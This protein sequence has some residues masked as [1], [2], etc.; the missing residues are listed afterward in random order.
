MIRCCFVSPW[1]SSPEKK[2]KI[3][4]NLVSGNEFDWMKSSLRLLR[5]WAQCFLLP[6]KSLLL[7]EELSWSWC[8]VLTSYSAAPGP[9]PRIWQVSRRGLSFVAFL[10]VSHELWSCTCCSAR[11]VKPW[12]QVATAL[13]HLLAFLKEDCE[14]RDHRQ[15]G[16]DRCEAPWR[17]AKKMTL[18]T[19]Y[20]MWTGRICGCVVAQV[21]INAAP[22]P[23]R[24]GVHPRA[25][26][27]RPNAWQKL[28]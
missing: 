23:T 11:A 16:S 14:A 26:S 5:K 9:I 1:S 18:N 8:P 20:G 7:V 22:E 17:P 25:A 13:A 24:R 10:W 28:P 21:W 4:G 15:V 19:M 3:P 27:M 2:I 6:L 12:L